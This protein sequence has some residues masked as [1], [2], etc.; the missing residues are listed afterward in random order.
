MSTPLLN[1]YLAQKADHPGMILLYRMGDFY[2]MFYEDAKIGSEVLGLTLTSRAHGKAADVPLAGFPHHASEKYIEQLVKAGYRVAI[3]EQVEDPKKAKGLVKRDVIEIVSAGTALSD[4]LL[5]KGKN[6]YLVAVVYEQADQDKESKIGMAYTDISTGDFLI[7]G[8][9]LGNFRDRITALEP[10]EILIP[11]EQED[12]FRPMIPTNSRAV[13]TRGEDWT[14]T[15][16][17]GQEVLLKHFE[18]RSLSGFGID[19]LGIEIGAAGALLHYLRQM[20]KGEVAVINRICRAVSG[21]EMVLDEASRR[22]L[23]LVS[24]LMGD[25]PEA[26]LLHTIDRTLTPPGKRLLRQRLLRPSRDVTEIIHRLD[27]IQELIKKRYRL[28]QFREVMKGFGD[29]ERLVARLSSGRGSPKDALSLSGALKRIPKLKELLQDATSQE[30]KTIESELNPLETIADHINRALVD[31][32]PVNIS[33]GEVIRDGY[34]Q[35]LDE[36]RALRHNSRKW[37]HDQQEKERSKTGISSLKIGYNQVFGYYIEVTKPHLSKVPDYFIRKQTLVNAERFITP[38]LK[39]QEEKILSADERILEREG[40]LWDALRQEI[41]AQTEVIQ[42]NSRAIA[43]LDVTW[44][45][46]DLALDRRWNR[47]EVTTGQELV[48]RNG[49]HPVVENLLP[50]GENFIPNDVEMHPTSCQ[51]LVITGPN[52]A[53]K[54]TYLRQ[55][56]LIVILAQMGSFIPA[57]EARIGMVDRLFTRV[58]AADNLAGGESTFLVEMNEVA[59]I[60]NNATPQSLVLLDEVGRGTSTFDGLSLAWAIAEYLHQTKK[61]TAKTLFATHY[62]ELTELE[63]YLERV[64]NVNVAVKKFGDKVLFLRKIQPGGCDHSYGIDVARLA[65]L[66]NAVIDRAQEILTK[67][68]TESVAPE[69]VTD[70]KKTPAPRKLPQQLPLF[71]T[72]D[73]ALRKAV[74]DVDLSS[75]KSEEALKILSE[76]K[77]LI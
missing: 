76:L 47:P 62:H 65:G 43:R 27:A 9:S 50:A 41:I 44:S 34:D 8:I 23:E 37:I 64:K 5:E 72:D 15:P 33:A 13:I 24:S 57:D 21:T 28:P 58:G 42:Q 17:Y 32:P 18:V 26:T 20:R 14:F 40:T 31:N 61:L 60:L 73:D 68:E 39:E 1:Q 49:R 59:N 45:M 12:I 67:L 63:G 4:N 66:P 74:T 56:G 36:L 48:I 2:E 75:L 52:M 54:S 69:K 16:E 11:V 55:V 29:P 71:S 7:E 70:A 51:I 46:A 19:N 3:C 6:N 22:N 30:L 53:G 10:S 35:E 77:K 38:E 25:R